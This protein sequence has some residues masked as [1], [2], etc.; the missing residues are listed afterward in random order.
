MSFYP[1]RSKTKSW[2][3]HKYVRKFHRR[4]LEL[5]HWLTREIYIED[6]E[7]SYRFR[8]ETVREFNRCLKF[9]AKEPGTFEWIM[10]DVKQGD[11]FYDIGAN[12]G[13]YTILAA[14]RTGRQ[15][16]VYAFEPH[17]ANFSRLIDNLTANNLQ[18]VVVPCNFALNDQKGFFLFNYS[19]S[20]AG[21]SNSQLTDDF[22]VAEAQTGTQVSEL[23]YATTIDSL[24]ES[25]KLQFPN[26]VKIDVDGNEYLILKGMGHLFSSQDRPKSVQVEMNDP[27]K[28]RILR[29]MQDH[30]YRLIHKHYTRSASRRIEEGRS[31]ENISY[32]AIF[33]CGN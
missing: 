16:K 7:T 15:G 23:K 17:S 29:F 18:Q 13:V 28:D 14:L 22:K 3:P 2:P 11:I 1:I 27:Y 30:N 20:N 5:R 26:H 21:T 32:N 33:Q 8:C 19:S 10:K 24:I 4:I 25:G 9:F 6:A 12:I 31:A